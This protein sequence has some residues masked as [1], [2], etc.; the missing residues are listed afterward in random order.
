[1]SKAI[2]DSHQRRF[3]VAAREVEAGLSLSNL[4]PAKPLFMDDHPALATPRSRSVSACSGDN[5]RPAAIA[6]K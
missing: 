5:F 2:T 1:M 6:T 3:R 4:I